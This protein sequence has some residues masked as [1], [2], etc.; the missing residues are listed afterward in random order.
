MIAL[1]LHTKILQVLSES[2]YPSAGAMLPRDSSNNYTQSE[3]LIKVTMAQLPMITE[4]HPIYNGPNIP[5]LLFEYEVERATFSL[6]PFGKLV[7][8]I[9]SR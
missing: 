4:W 5:R 9:T 7:R 2:H 3:E 6:F 1:V 8:F